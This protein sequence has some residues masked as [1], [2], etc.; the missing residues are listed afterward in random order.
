MNYTKEFILDKIKAYQDSNFIF[1]EKQ[2]VYTYDGDVMRGC[3]TFLNTFIEPFKED[4]WSKRKA[5][6]RGIT[7][8]EILAE[9]KEKRDRSTYLG[10]LIHN[11][12]EDYYEKDRSREDLTEDDEANMRIKKWFKIY[13]KQL[14][15]LES[16]ASEI[17]VFS[18]KYNLAGTIDKLYLYDGKLIIG[19]WKSNKQ[20]RTDDDWAFNKLLAPFDNV[21]EN[22][23]NKYSLQLSIYAVLLEEVGLEVDY[24]FIC[25]IPRD[26]A[27][28]VIYKCKDFRAEIKNYLNNSMFLTENI[29]IEEESKNNGYEK[30]W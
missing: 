11:Y 27:E 25:H 10:T 8:E 6:E 26:E 17:K 1:E 2:H 22:E 14:H 4:Y 24:T 23:L 28:C 20:I 12:I 7:Q 18:K 5:D 3:T 21:K 16:V 15:K 9:W 19:D 29:N 30:I 13:D